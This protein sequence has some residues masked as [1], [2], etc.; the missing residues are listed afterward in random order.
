MIGLHWIVVIL[1]VLSAGC[2]FGIDLLDSSTTQRLMLAWHRSAGLLILAAAILPLV[3]HARYRKRLPT[4]NLPFFMRLLSNMVQ[5]MI[6]LL[7]VLLPVLGW[8]LSNAR[9]VTVPLWGWF[10]L[11][12][13]V[14]LNLD[15]ADGLESWLVWGAWLL[16][17]LIGLHALA[18]LWHHCLLRDRV[19]VSMWP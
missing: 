13:L 17:G 5:G 18:A 1:M 10:P 11:P 9:G 2:V 3:M 15:L 6:Y 4:H 8:M 19:L 14:A 12:N 16:Y 7:L